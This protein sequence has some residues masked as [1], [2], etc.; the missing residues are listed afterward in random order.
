M[1]SY[2][3]L[4]SSQKLNLVPHLNH[5]IHSTPSHSTSEDELQYYP[6]IYT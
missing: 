4:S 3:S 6:P 1:E 2:G 5:K